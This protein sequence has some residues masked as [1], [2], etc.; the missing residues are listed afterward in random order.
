M[1]KLLALLA[2][3]SLFSCGE[4]HKDVEPQELHRIDSLKARYA[5]GL[6]KASKSWDQETGWPSA[7]DCD[8]TLWA[9]LAKAGGVRTVN[10]QLAKQEDGRI[11][12]R[13]KNP[14]FKDGIDLGSKST[15]SKDML[16]G[17]VYGMFKSGN[18][19]ELE[20]LFNY[21]TEHRWVMG[22]PA[23][24]IGRVV[25]TPNGIA[26]L[27]L[28]IKNLGG[29]DKTE[30][31][32]PTSFGTGS[33]DYEQHLAVLGIA[34]WGEINGSVPNDAYKT[35]EALVAASPKDALFQAVNAAYHDGNYS[36]AVSLLLDGYVY[37]TYVRGSE[38]YQEVHWLFTA[39]YILQKFAVQID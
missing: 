11:H 7:T 4:K 21:G 10:L 16:L 3:I 19:G 24:E 30:C 36:S 5:D 26:T 39:H 33:A 17:Y 32:L 9:G 12:R 37:P 27:C 18:K 14:C 25:L 15:I 23:S 2:T 38:H 13:P 1:K 20:Y 6:E 22:D 29:S 31:H 8:G 28:A 35:L 34:L